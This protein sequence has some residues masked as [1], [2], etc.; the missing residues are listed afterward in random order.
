VVQICQNKSKM[1]DGRHLE[2]QKNCDI[3]KT[4]GPISLKCGL[5]MHR[6]RWLP[7]PYADKNSNFKNP[8]W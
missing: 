2:N 6:A 3:S 8:I 5:L 4:V 1:A 7:R